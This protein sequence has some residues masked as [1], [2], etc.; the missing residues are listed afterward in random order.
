M[1]NSFSA[2]EFY[3]FSFSL[4]IFYYY[5]DQKVLSI[6]LIIAILIFLVLVHGAKL[7]EISQ[8]L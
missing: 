8:I 4:I 6:Y 1:H 7:G 3:K 2:R 5:T